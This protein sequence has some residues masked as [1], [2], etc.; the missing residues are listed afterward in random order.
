MRERSRGR[1]GGVEGGGREGERGKRLE[2]ESGSE[3][4]QC[5]H[6]LQRAHSS[7]QAHSPR[8]FEVQLPLKHPRAA[9]ARHV[10]P[11]TLLTLPPLTLLDSNFP[12]NSL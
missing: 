5:E 1:E 9:A 4:S 3:V 11:V 7:L 6:V 8:T 10:R 12:G 2:R